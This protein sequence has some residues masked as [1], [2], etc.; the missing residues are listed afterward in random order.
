MI[1]LC[2]EA[3]MSEAR[4]LALRGADDY[5][6]NVLQGNTVHKGAQALR[7]AKYKKAPKMGLKLDW[8]R[9]RDSNSRADYSTNAF[10]VRPGT[11]TSVHLQNTHSVTRKLLFVKF[12]LLKILTMF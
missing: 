6:S 11:T 8:R 9:R 10:R 3:Y 1:R 12:I 5:S 4:V 7:R 2:A